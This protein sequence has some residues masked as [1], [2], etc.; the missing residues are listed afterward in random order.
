MHANGTVVE[1]GRIVL[2]ARHVLPSGSEPQ[3]TDARKGAL[4]AVQV[5]I[6]PLLSVC[7]VILV[8]H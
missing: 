4:G 8:I 1:V 6:L 2:E 7:C 3:N 5:G